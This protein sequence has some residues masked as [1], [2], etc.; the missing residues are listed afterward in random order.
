MLAVA[1]AGAVVEAAGFKMVEGVVLHLLV[2]AEET[3]R[4]VPYQRLQS[5]SC[6]ILTTSQAA[7][8]TEVLPKY[9]APMQ[10]KQSANHKPIGSVASKFLKTPTWSSA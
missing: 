4:V 2:V 9:S 1:V 10:T 5:R 7:A 6:L 8:I 3:C